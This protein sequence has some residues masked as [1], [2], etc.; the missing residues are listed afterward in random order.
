[1]M[2]S[3]VVPGPPT[4]AA[5]FGSLAMTDVVMDATICRRRVERPL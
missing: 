3:S 5:A 2:R 1:M 4:K